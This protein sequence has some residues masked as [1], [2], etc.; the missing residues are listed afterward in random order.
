M[1][2]GVTKSRMKI[3]AAAAAAAAA[4]IQPIGFV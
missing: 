2:S 3:A 1:L 4:T